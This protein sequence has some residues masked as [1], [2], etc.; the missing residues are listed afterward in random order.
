MDGV[1]LV[2]KM[3][4]VVSRRDACGDDFDRD[5]DVMIDSRWLPPVFLS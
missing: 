5:A 2:A 1:R 3:R 4:M